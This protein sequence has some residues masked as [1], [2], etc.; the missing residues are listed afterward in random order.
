MSWLSDAWDGVTDYLG[1]KWEDLKYL[2]GEI[3]RGSSDNTIKLESVENAFFGSKSIIDVVRDYKWHTGMATD[4]PPQHIPRIILREYELANSELW[5]AFTATGVSRTLGSN[6]YQNLYTCNPT[7]RTFIYPYLTEDVWETKITWN[8]VEAGGNENPNNKDGAV[9]GALKSVVGGVSSLIGGIFDTANQLTNSA[10]ATFE[11]GRM[12][13]EGAT[14]TDIT[15]KFYIINTNATPYTWHE[16]Y[17]LCQ[18]LIVSCLHDQMNTTKATPPP[19]YTMYIPGMR[20]SPACVIS[21]LKI[22]Q[23][24]SVMPWRVLC[25][26]SEAMTTQ[27]EPRL[28]LL[29]RQD[30]KPEHDTIYIPDAWEIEIGFQDLVKPSRQTHLYGMSP[31]RR[32]DFQ[33]I[34]PPGSPRPIDPCVYSDM[35]E[36]TGM[37]DM[38]NIGLHKAQSGATYGSNAYKLDDEG[39]IIRGYDISELTFKDTN[40][41]TGVDKPQIPPQRITRTGVFDD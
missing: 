15:T 1:N 9:L 2:G 7:H 16:N 6:P 4:M 20:Y 37:M 39:K 26:H 40:T 3:W 23:I 32:K 25:K 38:S 22:R 29:G 31:V 34:T 27:K 17:K 35:Y 19:I 28:P 18:Y 41:L 8:E 24:G 10:P 30:F 13:W 14:V 12:L 36:V 11:N 21:S 5:A 33:A